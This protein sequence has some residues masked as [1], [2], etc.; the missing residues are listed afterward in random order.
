MCPLL[1]AGVD[2]VFLD[3]RALVAGSSC[4]VFGIGALIAEP[5]ADA[6]S[7]SRARSYRFLVT[8]PA[9]VRDRFQISNQM[10]MARVVF[11]SII[12]PNHSLVRGGLIRGPHGFGGGLIPAHGCFH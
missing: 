8:S 1:F 10:D 12:P 6:R 2:P 3:P 11:W 4:P 5:K 7:V 9:F